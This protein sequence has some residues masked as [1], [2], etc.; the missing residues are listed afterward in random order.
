MTES[1]RYE[2]LRH[3]KWVDEVIPN[4]PWV[5]TREFLD[6]HQID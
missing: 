6:E 5:I 3:C 4:A 2:S 1:K